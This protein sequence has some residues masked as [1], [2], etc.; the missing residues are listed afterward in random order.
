MAETQRPAAPLP[1]KR[2][3]WRSYLRAALVPLL[4]IEL[5][6]LL[7][8]WLT[9]NVV[10]DRSAEA[11]TS[12][13][14]TALTDTARREGGVIA[15]RLE[16]VTALT[17]IYAAESGR[18]LATPAPDVPET[19]KALHALSPDGVF[20][21]TRD[22]GGSAVFFSGAVPVGEAEQDKVWRTLR[23]DPLM[24]SIVEADPLVTQVYVNTWDSL[25]RIYPFFDVLS[26]YAPGMDIPTYNFYYEADEAHNPERGVVWTDAYLDPAGSGWMVSAIAP[27]YSPQR[28]EAV[29]G[30]DVT[31]ADIIAGVL[32][33]E[34]QDDGYAIL[35]SRDGTILA[36]PPKGEADFGLGELTNVDYE[37]A[38]LQDTFKPEAFNVFRRPELAEL[39]EA[40]QS[41]PA[42]HRRVE[43]SRPMIAAWSTVAGPE[44]K[45]IVLTSEA[46]VLEEASTLRGQLAFVS[47]VMLGILILFYLGF[48]AFLWYRS[49]AMSRR[50]A[51]P[52]AEI[53]SNMAR[54]AEGGRLPASHAYEVAEV[55]A[56]GD[57]LVTMGEKLDA[58]NKAKSNFLSAMSHELRTPLNAVIGLA[59][60]LREGEI[61][62]ERTKM[63]RAISAAGWQLLQL[64]E[65]VI[66][67]S[68]IE[69]AEVEVKLATLD[70]VKIGRAAALTVRD[71]AADRNISVR[72]A[73]P[74]GTPP[75]IRADAD[76]LGRILQQILSNAVKY[77]RDGGE[78]GIGFAVNATEVAISVTDNGQG[79]PLERQSRLFTPFDRLGHE[80]S[81]IS[82]A[83]IGLTVA[84]RLGGLMD[85]RITV[86]SRP[87]EGST[88]TV[89]VPKAGTP[90]KA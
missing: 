58:A 34:L 37:S 69:K 89:H 38:V 22:T 55:Q 83:G 51:Q 47:E 49:A 87:G 6:F 14:T 9:T 67:L 7:I 17:H 23:L 28:L 65:G 8:Y 1:L 79:I 31:V 39:V 61:D 68:R 44:W 46:A 33:M 77:N 45:L 2:W 64:V 16:T 82:G 63:A 59:D 36:L 41:A 57:H 62:A 4:L 48:F 20:Y 80:N 3:L 60:L 24:K 25:N 52:L 21:K 72:V 88:F 66:D 26:T 74:Q 86:D 11:V 35:V 71:V 50:V 15:R 70:A 40:L 42:G 53:E 12:I 13:S 10:Y 75:M 30:I 43:L 84:Q 5:G 76:I 29:V 18:A 56:L 81:T 27:V 85:C 90:A 19:E 32:D 78:V 54:I 73:A